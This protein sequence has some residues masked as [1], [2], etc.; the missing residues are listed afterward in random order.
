MSSFFRKFHEFSHPLTTKIGSQIVVFFSALYQWS[1][2]VKRVIVLS[3]LKRQWKPTSYKVRIVF[4]GQLF[5]CYQHYFCLCLWIPVVVPEIQIP[6]NVSLR[7]CGSLGQCSSRF[8]ATTKLLFSLCALF[9]SC[10]CL[11][12]S[13]FSGGTP[14]LSSER[15]FLSAIRASF[16]HFT[17]LLMD[18]KNMIRNDMNLAR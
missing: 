11:T 1:S 10:F 7:L 13:M 4:N 14:F 5:H 15:N 9:A 2:H 6:V 3:Q 18:G 17:T 8:R 12:A 16:S